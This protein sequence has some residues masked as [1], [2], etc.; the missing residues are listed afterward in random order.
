[1][2]SIY[3]TLLGL[4][5][6]AGQVMAS[7]KDDKRK[8]GEQVPFTGSVVYSLP[9]TG[10]R[11]TVEAEQVKFVHG[12]Y[13]QYA[14][15]YLGIPNAPSTDRETWKITNVSLETYGEPDPNEVHKAS[16]PYASALSLTADG[17]LI[18]INSDVKLGK[19]E[20][21]SSVYTPDVEV[22]DEPWPDRS[23]HSF[24]NKVDSVS[25]EMYTTKTLQQK[26]LETAHDITKI[27][28]RKFKSLVFGYDKAL[29]DGEAYNTMVAQLD[30][31]EKKYVGLFIGKSYKA[32][33]TYVFNVVPG[34]KNGKS[35]IVFRFSSS[36]GVVP[37]TDLSGKPVMLELDPNTSLEKSN[38]QMAAVQ[39]ATTTETSD[40][41]L[42]YRIPGNAE[43][44][45]LDGTHTLLESHLTLAQFG[46]VAPIPEGLLNGNY[47]IRL[48]PATGAIQRIKEKNKEEIQ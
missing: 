26:A 7:P 13:Y 3:L 30:K 23:M 19:E 28:K 43:V 14:E 47:S 10:I 24:L 36:K 37:T 48:H 40:S 17:V 45:L 22:P 42:F 38:G 2:K 12:P 29:P 27:R 8:D 15:K 32:K 31:L 5:F 6:V 9:E 16:G 4:L 33:H 18:G 11:V 1:M 39:P 25:P 20:V 41:G 35:Q 46:K 34:A 44:R 21:S